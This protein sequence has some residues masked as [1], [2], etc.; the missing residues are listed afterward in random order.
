MVSG[1]GEKGEETEGSKGDSGGN[2]RHGILVVKGEVE[3]NL[4]E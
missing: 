2:V 3:K 1:G 4:E